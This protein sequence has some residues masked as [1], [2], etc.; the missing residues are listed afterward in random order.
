MPTKAPPALVDPR[1]LKALS[2]P[3]RQLI[4]DI[5]S[6]GPSSPIRI[7]RRLDDVSLNLVSHH[8]KVLKDLGCVELIDT[9]QRR[10]ATEH[11]YR[12]S[13]WAMLDA[14]QWDHIEPKDRYPITANILRLISEDTSRS[15]AEGKFEELSDN[16]LS[17]SPL[18]LDGEGWLEVVGT[19]ERALEEVLEAHAKSAERAQDSGETLMTARVVIMQY[20]LGRQKPGADA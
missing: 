13:Q 7:T 9:V 2:H 20:L 3:T 12:A 4:L 10:G 1:L 16:H 5:L 6:K 18:E 14:V 11:I 15:L 19:L 8:I 17:R